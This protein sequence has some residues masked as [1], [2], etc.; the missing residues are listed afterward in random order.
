MEYVDETIVAI[1]RQ[2]ERNG[3]YVGLA[4]D[5]AK[6]SEKNSKILSKF[7]KY[8]SKIGTAGTLMLLALRRTSRSTL[9]RC[10]LPHLNTVLFTHLQKLS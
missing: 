1:R 2:Q 7:A 8:G 4:A 5:M 10:L 9:E 6:Y 3:N